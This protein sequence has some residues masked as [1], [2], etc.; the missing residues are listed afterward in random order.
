M[1][2]YAFVFILGLIIG[3]FLNSVIYRLEIKEDLVASR[4][5]CIKC[6][7]ELNWKDLIP[8][9]SFFF[10]KARCRYCQ[11]KISW[12]Y[13]L[14]ELGLGVLFVLV[15]MF[16]SFPWYYFLIVSLLLIIFVYDLK[17]YLIPDKVIFL[18]SV[19]AFVWQVLYGDLI[20]SVL[21]ACLGAGLFL[22]LVLVSKETWMGWGDVKLGFFMGLF[23][24][25]PN[26]LPALFLGFFSGALIGVFLIFL[27][28]KGFKSQ[29]PFAPFL[30]F[31]TMVSLFYGTEIV[32]F[33][34]SLIGLGV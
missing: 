5:H 3:S 16:F 21:A 4:S 27:K 24:G 14:V 15:S 9:F 7:H 17:H 26:I 12:Q 1:I 2:E 23:L 34:L 8:V 29:V 33:Y 22:I 32:N 18:A 25:F 31:G 19:S 6:N 10:L 20:N 13:P 11:K 28:K 30:I